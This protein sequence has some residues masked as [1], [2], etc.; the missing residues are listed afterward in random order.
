MRTG[1]SSG[2][3]LGRKTIAGDSGDCIEPMRNASYVLAAATRSAYGTAS[4]VRTSASLASV[5]QASEMRRSRAWSAVVVAAAD[6]LPRSCR[7][8]PARVSEVSRWRGGRL[9]AFGPAAL[10][11]RAP[12]GQARIELRE[13]LDCDR[14]SETGALDRIDVV[15]EP[16]DLP[17]DA[18][19][20]RHAVAPEDARARNAGDALAGNDAAEQ[21][22][23]VGRGDADE[24]AIAGTPAHLAQQRDRV[25]QRV[26]LAG[27]ARDEA[28]AADLA[29]RLEPAQHAN[30][31]APRRQPRRLALDEAPA[32]DAVTAQQRARD[33]LERR[34][35]ERCTA[36]R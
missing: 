4:S 19:R 33:V 28:A 26:L 27:D 11:R 17:G 23:R 25:G 34:G 12:A 9:V 15:A 7:F 5:G 16:F 35:V 30:E 6:A 10:T 13:R 21:V 31:I 24:R 1:V 32:D 20:Q 8:E 29:T 22:R 36:F 3:A 14:A 2:S 18:R